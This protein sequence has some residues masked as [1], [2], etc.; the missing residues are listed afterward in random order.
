[1]HV[2]VADELEEL[3]TS[4]FHRVLDAATKR[5]TPVLVL[6]WRDFGREE[7]AFALISACLRGRVALPGVTYDDKVPYPRPEG[8]TV[9]DSARLEWMSERRMEGE[10]YMITDPRA[11]PRT[12]LQVLAP[13]LEGG[14]ALGLASSTSKADHSGT[15]YVFEPGLGASKGAMLVF[16]RAVMHALSSLRDVVIVTQ[17]VASSGG[18][19]PRR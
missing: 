2:L 10:E 15:V 13:M 16:K 4:L 19:E 6:D 5:T 14:S 3:D 17:R 18:G 11:G 12:F 8:A 7:D 9:I 1:V